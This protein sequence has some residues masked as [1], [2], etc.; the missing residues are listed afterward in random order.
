MGVHSTATRCTHMRTHTRPS[1]G[2]PP[3][4]TRIHP[5]A[6]PTTSTLHEHSPW[7]VATCSSKRDHKASALKH[8]LPIHRAA[9]RASTRRTADF[10]R[11]HELRSSSRQPLA[12]SLHANR[13]SS[14]VPCCCKSRRQN[15]PAIHRPKTPL[16][17]ATAFR[18]GLHPH[19]DPH[20]DRPH[21]TTGPN[22]VEM[23]GALRLITGEM[24]GALRLTTLGS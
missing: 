18:R 3:V 16:Q 23:R 21:F 24:R 11:R 7:M 1:D 9:S 19:F 8:A 22:P 4:S 5:V 20:F 10:Q 14:Q 17:F 13:C 12:T 15:A 6:P 2:S